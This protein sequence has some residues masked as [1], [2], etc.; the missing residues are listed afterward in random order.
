MD[1]YEYNYEYIQF[2]NKLASYYSKRNVFD[3]EIDKNVFDDNNNENMNAINAS[4]SINKIML[5]KM[6]LDLTELNSFIT[7]AKQFINE[8]Y[9]K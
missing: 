9:N 2:H 5:K 1:Y 7:E 4:I 6:N 8:F 3:D